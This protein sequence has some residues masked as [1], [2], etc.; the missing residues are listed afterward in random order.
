MLV[1]CIRDRLFV[2]P[3][4]ECDT[5]LLY[6]ENPALRSAPKITPR[7][8]Q[9]LWDTWTADDILRRHRVIGPLWSLATSSRPP[10]AQTKRIIWPSGFH[11]ASES[12]SIS[13]T[14]S[15]VGVPVITSA[16]GVDG[17]IYIKTC[18]GQILKADQAKAEGAET[19]AASHMAVRNNMVNIYEEHQ[20]DHSHKAFWSPLS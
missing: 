13:L 15:S 2:P 17:A 10:D 6:G 9:I 19:T 14:S 3:L 4:Q 16:D 7:D 11:L 18:D 20:A 8:R 12:M 1:Q 5:R